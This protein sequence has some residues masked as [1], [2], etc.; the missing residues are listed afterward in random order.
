MEPKYIAIR[1]LSITMFCMIMRLIYG[2]KFKTG[3]SWIWLVFGVGF[4]TLTLWPG[5]IDLSMKLIKV[6][7]WMEVV[8][9]YIL[10]FLLVINIH[11]SMTISGLA[12]RTKSLAQEIA[13][14]NHKIEENNDVNAKIVT[15]TNKHNSISERNLLKH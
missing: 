5:L 11:F 12:D 6:N 2:S 9:Y 14:L 10:I 8:F 1:L 15:D 4:L 7:S 13:F 3:A